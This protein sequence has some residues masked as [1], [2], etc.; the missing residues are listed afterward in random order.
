MNNSPN[1]LMIMADQLAASYLGTYG[2]SV[3]KTPNIDA[4][5]KRGVVFENAYSN[6]PICA[7]S[8]ASLLTGR[9]VSEIGAFDNGSELPASVPTLMHH[10]RRADYEVVLAGKA[11]FV[12]PDQMHGFQRRLTPE[13]Y[14]SDFSWTPDWNAGPVPNPG[15]AVD[16]LR[17]S[18]LCAWNLQLDHDEEVR[19]RSLE[20]LRDFARRKDAGK[21]F[22][23]CSSFTHPHEPF[24]T[25]QR[26]WDLY[27]PEDIDLPGVEKI[28]TEEMHAFDQWLQLHHMVD[29]YPLTEEQIRNTRHAYYSMVSYFDHQ[30][31]GLVAE[32]ERLGLDENTII[33]VTSDHGEMLGERG[34]WFK[35][36]YFENSVKVPLIFAGTDAVGSGLRMQ[37]EV[38]LVDLMPT[39]LDLAGLKDL[40]AVETTLAGESLGSMLSGEDQRRVEGIISEYYSEGVIQPMRMAVRDRFKYVYVHEHEAQLFDLRNDPGELNNCIGDPNHA[41]RLAQLQELVHSGWEPDEVRAR[42]IESQQRRLWIREAGRDGPGTS[43]D[44]APSFDPQEQY[45]RRKNAQQTNIEKRVPRVGQDESHD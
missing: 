29:E 7:P 28:P 19:F 15:T 12:G 4:L 10:L 1:I 21:P 5:A 32:L 38:S 41:V 17:D 35:R 18:G 16:Q 39:F 14:P 31:G 26:W 34:M 44:V 30:V 27:A 24:I 3:V 33:V 13:I 22:F 25:T 40:D 20:Y 45:V 36:T 6:C 23:L 42:V 11:H 43:W 8:R 37:K 9:H 2:H